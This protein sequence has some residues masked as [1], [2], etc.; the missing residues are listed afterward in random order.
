MD[1]EEWSTFAKKKKLLVLMPFTFFYI[2]PDK[3]CLKQQQKN[4]H[5]LLDWGVNEVHQP[6]D[7]SNDVA[8]GPHFFTFYFLVGSQCSIDNE[9]MK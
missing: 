1:K 2:I 3:V 8:A 4:S 5:L 9:I 7:L 6:P